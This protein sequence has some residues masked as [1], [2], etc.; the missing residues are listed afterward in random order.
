[1]ITQ[2]LSDLHIITALQMAGKTDE[3]ISEVIDQPIGYITT[4]KNHLTQLAHELGHDP[5]TW[6]KKEPLAFGENHGAHGYDGPQGHS[7]PNDFLIN[8]LYLRR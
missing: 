1:M 3:L 8:D 5:I 4:L 2:L 6:R 7:P